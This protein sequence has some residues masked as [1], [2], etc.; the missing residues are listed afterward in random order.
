MSFIG[1]C[2]DGEVGDFGDDDVAWK[3]WEMVGNGRSAREEGKGVFLF[4]TT[5]V[6]WGMFGWDEFARG[7]E[8]AGRAK[9]MVAKHKLVSVNGK[10]ERVN[11]YSS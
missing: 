8:T 3:T 10:W 6:V 7:E 2:D 11:T 1:F 5:R 4:G 9:V